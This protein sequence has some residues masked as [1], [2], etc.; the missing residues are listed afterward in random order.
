MWTRTVVFSLAVATLV[1]NVSDAEACSCVLDVPAAEGLSQAERTEQ[2][3]KAYRANV[4][5]QFD[6]SFAIFSAEV[7]A[8]APDMIT[9][10]VEDVWKGDLPR[11]LSMK[12]VPDLA[13]HPRTVLSSCDYIFKSGKKY[14]VVA[15][16]S[17]VE[18]M[19]TKA[20]TA[21]GEI[22]PDGRPMSILTQAIAALD[23][24]VPVRLKPRDR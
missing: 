2:F 10:N 20:C 18:T 21:T 8:L 11:V 24:L 1:A 3:H 9:F 6:E 13:A 16:G 19:M 23:E 4:R 22:P 5:K 17:S 12:G 15:Y 14:L 7:I